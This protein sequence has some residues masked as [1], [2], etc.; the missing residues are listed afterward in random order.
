MKEFNSLGKESRPWDLVLKAV[1]AGVNRTPGE[2]A[3]R[4]PLESMCCEGCGGVS[5]AGGQEEE[6]AV[7]A[8]QRQACAAFPVW[9]KDPAVMSGKFSF[10]CWIMLNN[11]EVT[12][13]SADVCFPMGEKA[14]SAV[15]GGCPCTVP[16]SPHS[17]AK[18][19][20]PWA[21]DPY[22]GLFCPAV[23]ALNTWPKMLPSSKV[24][25]GLHKLMLLSIKGSLETGIQTIKSF[26]KPNN[27]K[28]QTT[29]KTFT[30]LTHTHT[31]NP[32]QLS[33]SPHKTTLK[34]EP[35]T[36]YIARK[37]SLAKT[38]PRWC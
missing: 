21:A 20:K 15:K 9:S 8:T 19:G 38:V 5:L 22:Q 16:P 25:M 7:L 12:A 26:Q 17:S 29:D 2:M 35:P 28:T 1:C 14:N 34:K 24:R 11:N 6:W 27:N 30:V 33:P 13:V 23:V 36:S 18:V 31:P 37:L 4:K 10:A 32:K 3:E